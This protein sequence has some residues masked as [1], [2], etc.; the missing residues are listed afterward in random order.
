MITREAIGSVLGCIAFDKDHDKIGRIGNV[1][2]DDRTGDP[3]WMTVQT[4]KFGGRETFVP[5]GQADLQGNDVVL[6]Y[7]KEQVDNAPNI[8]AD[9]AGHLSEQDELKMYEYYGMSHPGAEPTSRT[10][11]AGDA[12]T[13]SDEVMRV[14][15]V[16]RG[17]NEIRD[18]GR[19]HLRRYVVAEEHEETADGQVNKERVEAEELAVEDLTVE[20]LAVEGLTVEDMAAENLAGYER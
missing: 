17:G 18:A 4:G 10:R 19:V 5:I 11:S 8:S 12:M 1:Y 9:R 16:M 13:R 6:P 20:D 7:Q 14:G 2:V 3:E 15:E